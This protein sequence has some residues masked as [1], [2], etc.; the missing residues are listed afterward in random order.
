MLT[1]L[2]SYEL[3]LFFSLCRGQVELWQVL[4]NRMP[5]QPHAHCFGDSVQTHTVLVEYCCFTVTCACPFEAP[6]PDPLTLLYGSVLN[7]LCEDATSCPLDTV[8]FLSEN[9]ALF[10][11]D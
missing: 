4:E 7:S 9:E 11:C 3:A 1:F 8:L 6:F 5:K 10:P 2:L